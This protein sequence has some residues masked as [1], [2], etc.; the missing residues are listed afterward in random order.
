MNKQQVK[1]KLIEVQDE[2]YKEFHSNLVPGEEKI[3]GVRVPKIRE[4]A[5]EVAKEDYKTFLDEALYSEDEYAEE[6]MVQG[7]VIGLSKMDVYARLEYIKIFVPKIDNWA[8]C[9]TFVPTLKFTKK[10]MKLMWDFIIPYLNS[11]S[12]Y[13]VR[14]ALVMIMDYYVIDEYI[15]DIFELLDKI[16]HEG[17]YVKMAV[18]WALSVCFIKYGEK[19]IEYFRNNSLDDWTYNK[20][21]QKSIESR[22]VDNETKDVLRSMKRK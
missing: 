13:D 12:E 21:L 15:D 19:T 5:K 3:L 11:D 20:A 10:N 1:Q 9:D 4:I 2:K 8:V 17:Y 6:I 16:S 18:A 14:F 22:R 7:M